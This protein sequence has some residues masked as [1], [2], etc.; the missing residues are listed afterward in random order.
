M[1]I[2]SIKNIALGL[3]LTAT[4]ITA[5][6]QKVYTQGLIVYNIDV[7][8][9]SVD[10]Q[11]YFKGDTASVGFQRG[12]AAIKMVGTKGGD[13]LAVFVDV[14]V[15]NMKKAAVG[16]PAELDEAQANE[17]VYAFTK[18]DETKKI[19]DFT[20][21]KYIS[22]DTRDGKTYDLWI[23]NDITVPAN[24]LTRY[25]ASLG[26]TPVLFTYLQGG[27]V[28]GAQTVTLKSISDVKVPANMFKVT[29]DYDKISLTDLQ[30]M[31]KGRQ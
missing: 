11:T 18:T 2:I 12:P 25:Y 5:K 31:G 10:A 26:G 13:Y 29:S 21:K 9:N 14:P 6:A 28:K 23:T 17:P 3:V 22:K 4:A 19:G 7:A 20:C 1:N 30:N 24:M 15:A 16:T 27:T 8:G